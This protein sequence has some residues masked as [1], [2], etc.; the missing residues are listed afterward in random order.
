MDLTAYTQIK[1][2]GKIAE[3]NG[4]DIPRLRGYRAMWN[5]Q[6]A[7]QNEIDFHAKKIYDIYVDLLTHK[8][9]D[10]GGSMTINKCGH[11]RYYDH[12]QVRRDARRASKRYRKQMAVF[13]QYCGRNDILMV[14]A[15]IGHHNWREYGGK[16]LSRQPW[17]VEKADDGFDDTY[18]DIYVK[19][20]VNG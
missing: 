4:I 13:N 11:L 1:D 19:I 17:F 8:K 16:E 14:H 2:L 9:N 18:C 15:R 7:T 12:R 6:P 10:Q 3:A 5:E 20:K